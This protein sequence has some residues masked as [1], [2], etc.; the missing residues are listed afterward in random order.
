[1]EVLIR[2]VQGGFILALETET[3]HG[4]DNEVFV[5]TSIEEA[6][7]FTHGQFKAQPE[8]FPLDDGDGGELVENP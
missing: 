7:S 6:L 2:Q 8:L 5:F 4:I 1:M 3:P